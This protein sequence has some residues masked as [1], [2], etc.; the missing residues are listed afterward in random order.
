[1]SIRHDVLQMHSSPV[2]QSLWRISFRACQGEDDSIVRYS[3]FNESINLHLIKEIECFLRLVSGCTDSDHLRSHKFIRRVTITL[4]LGVSFIKLPALFNI[5][6][7]L[8][9]ID[10]C[11]ERYYIRLKPC[12]F[13]L[14]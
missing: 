2:L 14:S 9:R 5:V 13:H 10:H 1:M 7:S 4:H 3:M 12:L 11:R 8:I 6:H